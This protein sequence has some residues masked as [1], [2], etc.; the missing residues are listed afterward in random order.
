MLRF[1]ATTGR[2][3]TL[4]LD[5]SV[6]E[7]IGQLIQAGAPIKAIA[8]GYHCHPSIV[9]RYRQNI[10]LFDVVAPAPPSVQ[11]RPRKITHEAQEGMLDW[12]LK[13]GVDKQL[14]YLDEIAIFLQEE[15]GIHVSKWTIGRTLKEVKISYEKVSKTLYEGRYLTN[16]DLSNSYRARRRPSCALS[17]SSSSFSCGAAG[18]C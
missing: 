2:Q 17:C 10:E 14:S 16:L 12:L 15:Y 1:T 5:Q 4:R 6:R 8:H 9:R 11:G 3:S 7:T 18:L 13:N